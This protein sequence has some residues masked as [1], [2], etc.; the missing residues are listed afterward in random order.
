MK[1]IAKIFIISFLVL[2]FGL[3]ISSCGK[4]NL[5]ERI[6]AN[7]KTK[8]T[9]KTETQIF[10][11]VY[12]IINFVNDDDS[13]IESMSIKEGEIHTILN[14]PTKEIDT[15]LEGGSI[16]IIIG[17]GIVV[18]GLIGVGLYYLIMKKK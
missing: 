12:Y 8:E 16:A 18:S 15:M 2:I 7:N 11:E 5:R 6:L 9:T 1:K 4:N 3:S 13:I 17:G 14:N 10:I